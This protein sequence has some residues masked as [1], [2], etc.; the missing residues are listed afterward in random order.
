M[1]LKDYQKT[2]LERVGKYLAFVRKETDV[3]NIRHASEDAWRELALEFNLGRYDEKENGLGRDVPNFVL[4]IPTGGGK[5]FLA[6]KTID[7]VNE[8]FR[9]KRTGLVLWVVPTTS[10]FRQT[11]KALKDRNHPYRQHL[12]LA[13]GGRTL[14]LEK[15][16]GRIDR[17][18]PL[19]VEE[20]L[21]VYVLML[22][23]AA[24]KEL[25]QKDLRI[26]ADS[27]GFADFFPPDDRLDQHEKLLEQYSNLETFNEAGGIWK[28]QIKTSLGNALRLLNPVV[29][30]DESQKAY[31]ETAQRT[32]L[33][34]NPSI[35]VELSATPLQGSNVLVDIKGRE[36]NDEE[37]IKLDL[38]ITNKG[39]L[40]WKDTLWVSV[41]KQEEL[42]RAAQK[43][44]QNS[45]VYI[46]PICLI[47][48]ERVGS[49]QRGRGF[50][51]A[52]DVRD[53]LIRKGIPP[54]YIAIK[55][56][57]K[58]ELK[59]VDDI[60]GL[61]SRDC[62]VR[63]I[64]TKQA[65]QEGWDCPFA[66]IL[67]VLDKM[68]SRMALTQLVGRILRQPFAT[69]T[70]TQLLDESYVYVYRQEASDLLEGIKNGFEHEGLGDLRTH[71]A[72]EEGLS[73][74]RKDFEIKEFKIRK[75][76]EKVAR[77][78][79]LPFFV[80]QDG[81]GWRTVNYE[82]DILSR[83]P[84]GKIDLSKIYSLS[85]I[86][87][88]VKDDEYV[89]HLSE[90]VQKVIEKKKVASKESGGVVVDEIFMA[91]QLND[92]ISNPWV[93][94][95]FSKKILNELVEKYDLKAVAQNFLFIIEESKR[96]MGEQRDQ[97]AKEE[98]LRLVRAGE[99][100]FVVVGKD[101]GFAMPR[102]IPAH[103]GIEILRRRDGAPIQRSLF[104]MVPL[105][106]FNEPE[107][108]VAC[109][110]DD[111]SRLYFWYRNRSRT[112]Y[113]IQAWRKDRIYPD[114]IFTVTEEEKKD[115]VEK[116]YIVE[117]KG[118][119][120]AGSPDTKYKES[121]FE[122]CNE[123]VKKAR[124]EEIPLVFKE[125]PIDYEVIYQPEWERRLSELFTLEK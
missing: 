8:V 27:G 82:I 73:G 123:L 29:I 38:H 113:G 64:I 106:Q 41:R 10:I 26:F 70:G 111:Q 32:I 74:Y 28:R 92:V 42:E 12:D 7:I 33:G 125:K 99:I 116:I 55:T 89:A 46:R 120:L 103:S 37:M 13:S 124:A 94:Y 81:D 52:D 18:M 49:E 34:F 88:E 25:V 56:S 62:L 101:F 11:V 17:F 87:R 14:I 22:Q 104:E 77:Q 109:F 105:E 30:L 60:G 93:A 15:Y 39:S 57:E 72:P 54:E 90:D 95:E 86:G 83:I 107:K 75:R 118:I 1:E 69:K 31:S 6:V 2:A 44:E 112:D 16:Q 24:R 76:F 5:T 65:L 59:D 9:K 84:F 4:K 58:D 114:F 108:Q 68:H 78:I 66:Y 71:I 119:Q 43:Y 20:N 61:M 121:V 36:L 45:G 40:D 21:V 102:K 53:E 122:L 35:V 50:I 3:G 51:H 98:F 115:V 100:R 63:Y 85:L 23:S 91:Q 48:V 79:I 117:T 19:D 96:I 47:R 80:I 97:I 67:A 110:L